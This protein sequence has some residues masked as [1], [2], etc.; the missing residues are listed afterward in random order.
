MLGNY[1]RTQISVTTA[2]RFFLRTFT[3]LTYKTVRSNRL[4]RFGVPEFTTEVSNLV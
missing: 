3:F 4:G 1:S 2:G